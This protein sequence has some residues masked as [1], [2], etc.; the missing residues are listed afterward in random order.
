MKI[1]LG[2]FHLRADYITVWH[3]FHLTKLEDI[4]DMSQNNRIYCAS[5]HG[6]VELKDAV[7]R[8]LDARGYDVH[9]LGAHGQ[10]QLIIR[11]LVH[12]W[13]IV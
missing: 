7:I 2:I 8:H 11:I 3:M 10:N 5:D 13:Q 6:G 4:Y 1:R 12:Y 9:D